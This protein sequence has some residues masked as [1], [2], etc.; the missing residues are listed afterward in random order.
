MYW[1]HSGT[2]NAAE[3]QKCIFEHFYR[4]DKAKSR[5]YG[6]TALGLTIVGDIMDIHHGTVE[7][8]SQL[9]RGSTSKDY[10]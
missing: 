8:K 6:G 9:G 7:V 10:V 1:A 3:Y 4:G 5:T 2:C